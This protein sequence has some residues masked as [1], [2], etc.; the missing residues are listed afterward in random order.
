MHIIWLSTVFV[1]GDMWCWPEN[2]QLHCQVAG[3]NT[4]FKNTERIRAVHSIRVA[5]KTSDWCVSWGQWIYATRLAAHTDS[6]PSQSAGTGVH[7]CS[8]CHTKHGRKVHRGPETSVA[9]PSRWDSFVPS[10]SLQSHLCMCN[11]AQPCNRAETAATSRR[12]Y[13]TWRSR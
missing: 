1:V 5:K 11:A 3:L 4:R 8:L 6:Q 9:L 10:E 12:W 7:G 2:C 13:R